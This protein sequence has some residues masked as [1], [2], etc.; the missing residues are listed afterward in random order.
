MRI[1]MD[2]ITFTPA[3]IKDREK[4][5]EMVSALEEKKLNVKEFNQ[6][7]EDNIANPNIYYLVARQGEILI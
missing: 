1:V 5:Y 4:V 7:F 2:K 3:S 6:V